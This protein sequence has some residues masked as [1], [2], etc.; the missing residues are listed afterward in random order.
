[1]AIPASSPPN[2]S[3][4]TTTLHTTTTMSLNYHCYYYP[5]KSSL[6]IFNTLSSSN[7]HNNMPSS[8]K[9]LGSKPSSSSP[10]GHHVVPLALATYAHYDIEAARVAVESAFEMESLWA[11][12]KQSEKDDLDYY[13]AVDDLERNW[14]NG[15]V[16]IRRKRRRK[17][18]KETNMGNSGNDEKVVT[19]MLILKPEN[20]SGQYLSPQQEADYT[21]CLKEEAR[22]EA[23][24]KRIEEATRSEVTLS[25]WAKAAGLSRN[26]LDKILCNGREARDRITRCYRRLVISLASGYQG[27][28]FSLQDLVQ[29]GNLGLIHGAKK[30]NPEKGYKLST[31]VYW[32][33][34][35]SMS[36]A[37]AKKSRL[38]RL[39]GSISELVPKICE[40]NAVLS[41]KLRKLPT[42]DEIAKLINKNSLTVA[43]TLERNRE[44]ISLD[45]AMSASNMSLQEIVPGPDELTPDT[46]VEKQ[47][48]K[49]DLDKLLKGLSE[50]ERSIIRLY[51]GL[52]GHTPLS[53]EDIGRRL[54]LSRE[55]VRQI[56]CGALKKLR[57]NS[58]LNDLKVYIA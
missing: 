26:T 36:R 16:L 9:Q 25:Q 47:F 3:S 39:P 4:S 28:G 44:P 24:R 18:R 38:T 57:E 30:F 12:R 41:Q 34:K 54:K 40:A 43:L 48:I 33:I 31:Y 45:Q 7:N 6:Q 8:S 10:P 11:Y 23:V 5:T 35:Q 52:N 53:F 14:G 46:M 58:M 27:R 13:D 56:S 21:F 49:K 51:Y 55:R 37:V 32:W 2:H 29:E 1:M 42:C 20:S 19:D 50:R 15:G 22:I 17:R